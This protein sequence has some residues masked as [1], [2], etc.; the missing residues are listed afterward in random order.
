MADG[1]IIFKHSI[2]IFLES[3]TRN[4]GGYC[5]ETEEHKVGYVACSEWHVSDFVN[6]FTKAVAT[7]IVSL[8]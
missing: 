2:E 1:E 5:R 6:V 3:T 8:V 7:M 4:Y